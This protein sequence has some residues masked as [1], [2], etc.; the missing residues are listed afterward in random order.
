MIVMNQATSP[1]KADTVTIQ[2]SDNGTDFSIVCEYISLV[3]GENILPLPI[4][5]GGHRYWRVVAEDSNNSWAVYE[6]NFYM[7]AVSTS[8]KIYQPA[9]KAID[10]DPVT[11]WE[12]LE[13]DPDLVIDLGWNILEKVNEIELKQDSTFYAENITVEYSED[14]NNFLIADTFSHN[15]T[16]NSSTQSNILPLNSKPQGRF[17]KFKKSNSLNA[18]KLKDTAFSYEPTSTPTPIPESPRNPYYHGLTYFGADMASGWEYD[19]EPGEDYSPGSI[20]ERIENIVEDKFSFIQYQL[21]R[22]NEKNHTYFPDPY[23]E[24]EKFDYYRSPGYIVNNIAENQGDKKIV[25]TFPFQQ[26]DQDYMIAPDVESSPYLE[27]GPSIDNF[28]AG[29]LAQMVTS[30]LD[31]IDLDENLDKIFAIEIGAEEEHGRRWTDWDYHPHRKTKFGSYREGEK[32]AEVYL[33]V[34]NELLTYRRKDGNGDPYG[35]CFLNKAPHKNLCTSLGSG[36]S[37]IQWYNAVM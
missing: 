3:E 16:Y 23:Q 15:D 35:D 11:Y 25:L 13:T 6:F 27:Y 8:A 36:R 18:W 29:L 28:A 19:E 21:S 31:R 2:Y 20:N 24:G 10:E 17:F 33:I 12:S 14:G 4:N 5:V 32:F 7:W 1:N 22:I 34:K 9:Y 30:V 26:S 37:P